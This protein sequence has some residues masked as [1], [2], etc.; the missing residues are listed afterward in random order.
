MAMISAVVILVLLYR[1]SAY[2]SVPRTVT[3]GFGDPLGLLCQP[4]FREITRLWG[5]QFFNKNS[6]S[7]RMFLLLLCDDVELNPGDSDFCPLCGSSVTDLE[8]AMCCDS[9]DHWVHV[10][11]DPG[12][13]AAEYDVLVSNPSSVPWLC[14][15][16][17]G[18][19]LI[20]PAQPGIFNCVC[21]NARG[22]VSKKL[23]LVAYI[24][25]RHVD[26][27]SVT[28]SFLDPDVSDSELCPPGFVIF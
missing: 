15:L 1:L 28:E 12:I 16:C 2:Y 8:R 17:A 6:L 26:V 27:L 23:D 21:L 5:I 9:C 3:F 19:D 20:V 13:T 18:E 11:C 14:S 22:I 10:S 24:S 25:G 4:C 7:F